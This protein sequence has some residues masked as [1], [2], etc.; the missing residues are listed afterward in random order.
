MNTRLNLYL[1]FICALLIPRN[2]WGQT[3]G[4]VAIVAG[5]TA[6]SMIIPPVA[7]QALT[8]SVIDVK[9]EA[10]TES[11]PLDR[12]PK[13][14]L[15]QWLNLPLNHRRSASFALGGPSALHRT[16]QQAKSEAADEAVL[17]TARALLVAD[18][19]VLAGRQFQDIAQD[20]SAAKKQ[21][22]VL[23]N[24]SLQ[25]IENDFAVL[26]QAATSVVAAIRSYVNFTKQAMSDD[27]MSE[28]E[29]SIARE[30]LLRLRLVLVDF[31]RKYSAN[32]ADLF[33]SQLKAIFVPS[34][35]G[36]IKLGADEKPISAILDVPK[37]G[38]PEER[39]SA[40]VAAALK[41]TS[42]LSTQQPLLSQVGS[43][44]VDIS[45]IKPAVTK[46]FEAFGVPVAL[47]HGDPEIPSRSIA[48][49]LP[50]YTRQIDYGPQAEKALS[51]TYV[52]LTIGANLGPL[53]NEA[54]QSVFSKGH[55]I[56]SILQEDKWR[57]IN[58][59]YSK[60]HAGD[61]NAIIYFDN[62]L[63]PI[64]KSATFD[65][66]QF[67]AAN[68]QLHRRVSAAMT[69]VFRVPQAPGSTSSSAASDLNLFAT[70]ARKKNADKAAG[71]HRDAL[72]AT[73]KE[74]I[75]LHQAIQ[76]QTE[77]GESWR[78]T[79]KTESGAKQLGVAR[80][81][82]STLMQNLQK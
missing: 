55:L 37:N 45:K 4:E 1:V 72:L 65:P 69:E 67:I 74:L 77:S 44:K 80:S 59:A 82:L 5:A 7:A 81:K 16:L 25:P 52:G 31:P 36:P 33:I 47:L 13:M 75:D 27:I 39:M 14:R 53:V 58:H 38:T 8:Y 50:P 73:L 60:S 19:I 62:I 24:A 28:A 63:T 35:N 61:H 23:E 42:A 29:L 66:S 78:G 15:D 32:T 30:R 18:R 26:H 76:Q 3:G 10:Y 46:L 41:V 79:N 51:N 2:A 43:N 71:L 11:L 6:G 49:I 68:A 70:K 21:I 34:S 56:D 17:T 54:F 22:N 12:D 9:V 48:E 64:L 57:Q 40:T 20:T